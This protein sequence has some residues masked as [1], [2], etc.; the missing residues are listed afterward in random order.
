MRN[1][2]PLDYMWDEALM[3]VIYV[4]YSLLPRT[5]T[6]L[7]FTAVLPSWGES[8]V[9]G[10]HAGSLVS[11]CRWI[12]NRCFED[13]A[14]GWF[15]IHTGLKSNWRT[16]MKLHSC[17]IIGYWWIMLGQFLSNQCPGGSLSV[18]ACG[19]RRDKCLF[20]FREE[21]WEISSHHSWRSWL[22]DLKRIC[23]DQIWSST[24][25]WSHVATTAF[26]MCTLVPWRSHNWFETKCLWKCP[27]QTW[28][29][30]G[31]SLIR[32]VSKA[33][34]LGGSGRNKMGLIWLELQWFEK[35]PHRENTVK[36]RE[37][38][39][40]DRERPFLGVKDYFPKS[41]QIWWI[42]PKSQKTEICAALKKMI[43]FDAIW[44]VPS[45]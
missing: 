2:R 1:G 40:K 45:I 41:P 8:K 23:H 30:N 26:N 36:Q 31:S 44:N 22:L 28:F 13:C 35:K 19:P 43:W 11:T 5:A 18:E 17:N 33:D 16:W 15:G 42:F 29:T 14:S 20:D 37:M 7:A 24:V 6:T 3:D 38:T 10:S 25:I 9:F 39:V 27:K 4:P 34:R 12:A 32:W 21:C